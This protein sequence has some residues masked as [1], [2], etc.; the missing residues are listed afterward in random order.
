MANTALFHGTAE[1]EYDDLTSSDLSTG[2][3]QMLHF[4]T[5]SEP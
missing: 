1:P 5:R 3:D 4:H 2:Y